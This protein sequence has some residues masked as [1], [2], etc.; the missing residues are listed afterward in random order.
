MGQLRVIPASPEY[1]VSTQD[2]HPSIRLQHLA[3]ITRGVIGVAWQIWHRK[4][5]W[6]CLCKPNGMP[7]FSV[8]WNEHCRSLCISF[9]S[10]TNLVISLENSGFFKRGC[11]SSLLSE[12][13]IT[14]CLL[15]GAPLLGCPFIS[16]ICYCQFS[17]IW[18]LCE[19]RREAY[20]IS[21]VCQWFVQSMDCVS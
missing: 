20:I 14:T 6:S 12:S 9:T 5:S 15:H 4:V 10:V 8:I 3:K 13:E 18:V 1:Q 17:R 19:W 11:R 16:R 7:V 21:T 2:W